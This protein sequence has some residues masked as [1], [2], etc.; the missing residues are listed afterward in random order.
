MDGTIKN[1]LTR[2]KQLYMHITNIMKIDTMI[3]MHVPSIELSTVAYFWV[4]I[5]SVS[6]YDLDVYFR[7][8]HKLKTR[9]KLVWPYLFHFPR[10]LISDENSKS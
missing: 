3:Y 6:P 2:N 1:H 9:N 7:N 10:M 8:V 4:F 5:L